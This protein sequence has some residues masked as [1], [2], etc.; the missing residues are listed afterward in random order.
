MSTGISFFKKLNTEVRSE[1]LLSFTEI[2]QRHTVY[3]AVSYTHLINAF[4][5]AARRGEDVRG[6]EMYVTLEPCSHYG[7]TPPCAKAI[8][9][10]GIKRVHIGI[11]DPNPKVAGCLLYTSRCV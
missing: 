11:L 9:G 3:I 7:R 10:H 1:F 2:C 8:I 5:D 4:E 6:A